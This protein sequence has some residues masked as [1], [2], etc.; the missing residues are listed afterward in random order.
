MEATSH[1]LVSFQ[2]C[3]VLLPLDPPPHSPAPSPPPPIE[4]DCQRRLLSTFIV[5]FLGF[6]AVANVTVMHVAQAGKEM[7]LQVIEALMDGNAFSKT[8]DE[9]G[10]VIAYFSCPNST[11][12]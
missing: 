4:L 10:A 9:D 5:L 7:P 1:A 11:S 12:I 8:K 6:I 2:G 3:C